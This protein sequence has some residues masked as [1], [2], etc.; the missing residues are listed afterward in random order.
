MSYFKDSNNRTSLDLAPGARTQTFWGDNML[1]SLVSIDANSTVPRHTHPHEQAGVVTE[2]KLEMG[3]GDEVKTLQPGDMYIIP[4]GV[5]HYA[6]PATPRPRPWTFSARSA[7]SSCT[8]PPVLTR[9]RT[10]P[11]IRADGPGQPARAADPA[12]IT[13]ANRLPGDTAPAS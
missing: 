1:L 4:G 12:G 11:L 10:V 9:R 8:D 6:G 7:P 2:G 3:I 5:E 13:P